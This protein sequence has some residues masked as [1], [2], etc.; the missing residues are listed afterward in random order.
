MTYVFQSQIDSVLTDLAGVCREV[1]TLVRDATEALLTA[2]ADIAERVIDAD[3]GIDA[4][5][6]NVEDAALEILS[7]QAPVATNLRIIVAALA[8][9]TDLDRMGDLAVHV[10]KIARLRT[11][12]VA[13]PDV[14]RPIIEQMAEVAEKM[15]ALT[16]RVIDDRDLALA[17]DLREH[18]DVMDELRRET[19]QR[20][21]AGEWSGGVE[22]AVDMALLSRYYERIA[23]H[24]VAV[25]DRVHFI[26]TGENPA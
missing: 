16:A 2:R 5:R 13:V 15:V 8:I 22:A 14:V 23:D 12:V 4:A 24:A 9:V 20:V 19:F 1:E 17:E 6:Q 7:L 26:V 11:P 21:L 3:G 25:A 10:A 18:D